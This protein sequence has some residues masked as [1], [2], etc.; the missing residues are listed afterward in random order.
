LKNLKSVVKYLYKKIRKR[1]VK[2]ILN[3]KIKNVVYSLIV[4]HL[5]VRCVCTSLVSELNKSAEYLQN[6]G[7]SE[8]L[9]NGGESDSYFSVQYFNDT[10]PPCEVLYF[11]Q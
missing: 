10:Q 7:K 5:L 4:V 9:Q 6:G 11:P 3:K 8:Y 1:E 2:K